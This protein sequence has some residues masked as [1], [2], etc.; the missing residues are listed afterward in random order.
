MATNYINQIEILLNTFHSEFRDLRILTTK[1]AEVL[2]MADDRISSLQ[3][4]TAH[5]DRWMKDIK[6]ENLDLKD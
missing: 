4:R 6:Q 2:Q 1:A 5:F 3:G